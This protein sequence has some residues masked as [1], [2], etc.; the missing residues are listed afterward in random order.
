MAR[1]ATNRTLAASRIHRTVRR[2]VPHPK[3]RDCDD[4]RA[5]TAF[6]VTTFGILGNALNTQFDVSSAVKIPKG[7]RAVIELVT[8]SI[9]VPAKTWVA[10]RMSTSLGFDASNI[11]LYLTPQ[12]VE[13]GQNEPLPRTRESW[14]ATHSLR[15][16]TDQSITFD[17]ARDYV[18]ERGDVTICV[19]GYIVS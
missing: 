1:K 7:K 8:A 14:V 11:D 5:W 3:S 6:H 12:G 18:A 19:S 15:A 13:S 10:L 16:Y 17:V 4:C 9:S 2:P